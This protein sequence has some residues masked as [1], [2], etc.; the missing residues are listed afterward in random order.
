M[1]ASCI[2]DLVAKS[3]Q[4][5]IECDP[6]LVP[7]FARSFPL[8]DVVGRPLAIEDAQAYG[9][10]IQIAAGSLPRFFRRSAGQFSPAFTVSGRF[11][12][13][14]EPAGE[15][16]SPNWGT[17]SKSVSR[18]A[19]AARPLPNGAVQRCSTNGR[20]LRRSEREVC[21]SPIR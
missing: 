15:S 5:V 9:V 17:V 7:L 6:R 10:D 19:A 3:A 1:F 18:G 13:A 2:P 14:R 8:A 11:T 21:E 16:V 4:C 20:G 12:R